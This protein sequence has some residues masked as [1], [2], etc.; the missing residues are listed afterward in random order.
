MLNKQQPLLLC[1]QLRIATSFIVYSFCEQITFTK[2]KLFLFLIK[3]KNLQLAVS[4]ILITVI[5][6]GYGLFPNEIL[7]RFFTFTVDSTDLNQV[8][9]A[10]M[11]LYIAMAAF[12]ILGIYNPAYWRSATIAN[13]LFMSGLAAG[14]F[15]SLV[16]DGVPSTLFSIG[17]ALEL[18]LACWGM[19]NLKKK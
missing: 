12:W 18:I 5:A 4:A 9:R 2:S 3:P 8:F 16:A 15:F 7:S 1:D 19:W 10:T 11:G 13:V 6:L 14:R 17:F